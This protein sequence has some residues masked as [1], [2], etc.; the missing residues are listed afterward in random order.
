MCPAG[1]QVLERDSPIS[2]EEAANGVDTGSS[3]LHFTDDKR[4]LRDAFPPRKTC[5][6][7]LW[8]RPLSHGPNLSPAQRLQQTSSPCPT[9]AIMRNTLVL[10]RIETLKSMTGNY[11]W[12]YDTAHKLPFIF[13]ISLCLYIKLNSTHPLQREKEGQWCGMNLSEVESDGEWKIY[14]NEKV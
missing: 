8:A 12:Y 2:L 7:L 14:L 13:S 11:G 3:Y 10:L 1:C 4:K 5:A 6:N 9:A